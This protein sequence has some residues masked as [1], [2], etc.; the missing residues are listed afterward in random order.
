MA[1]RVAATQ[2]TP[3]GAPVPVPF[4]AATDGRDHWLS[5]G[6]PHCTDCHAA[7]W[8]LAALGSDHG[9]RLFLLSYL[10]V[11]SPGKALVVH[12]AEENSDLAQA[13]NCPGGLNHLIRP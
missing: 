7:P 2:I 4:S 9:K 10:P 13:D 1:E 11:R 3:G 5:A 12:F 8:E 6:K